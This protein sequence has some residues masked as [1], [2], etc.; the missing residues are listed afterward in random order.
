MT[1]KASP[2]KDQRWLRQARDDLDSR[3]GD[4]VVRPGPQGTSKLQAIGAHLDALLADLGHPAKRR[5]CPGCGQ[6]LP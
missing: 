2:S 3:A 1:G 5:V 6:E 4:W